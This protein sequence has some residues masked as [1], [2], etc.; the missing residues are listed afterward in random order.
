MEKEESDVYYQH[1]Q[2]TEMGI[3]ES[4]NQRFSPV[5]QEPI[6]SKKLNN[7]S[8]RKQR[9]QESTSIN[10]RFKSPPS[11]PSLRQSKLTEESFSPKKKPN[12]MYGCPRQEQPLHYD[13]PLYC[14]VPLRRSILSTDPSQSKN[15]T[16][17]QMNSIQALIEENFHQSVLNT[18]SSIMSQHRKPPPTLVFHL[19]HNILLAKQ[20]SSGAECFRILRQIQV[21]HPAVPAQMMSQKITWEFFSMVVNLSECTVGKCQSADS[22]L[23]LNASL[24]LSFLI[25]TMEEEAKMKKFS[26]VKTSAYRLLSVIKRLNNIRDVAQWIGCSVARHYAE[27]SDHGCGHNLCPVSL[28]QRMLMLS[29]L[30]SERPEDSAAR[31]AEELVI[32]YLQLQSIEQKAMFLQSMQSHL[33]RSKVIEVI[34]SNCPSPAEQDNKGLHG[35]GFRRILFIDFKRFPPDHLSLND[36]AVCSNTTNCEEFVMILAYWLQ[37]LVFCQ[38]KSH[39]KNP[40]EYL[41]ML[42]MDDVDVLLNIDQEVW[43]LRERLEDLCSPSPLTTRSYQLL[44]MMSALKSIGLKLP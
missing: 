35:V 39:Q 10:K 23:A 33:V 24:A 4:L 6:C 25:S 3:F 40:S 37:S 11:S 38:N 42:S 14:A 12:L 29:L 31:I 5:K 1:S 30:V 28:L 7:S 18:I 21:L 13:T 32:V 41:R 22:S 43:K 19:L 2:T 26:L 20:S 27:Q 36:D 9:Y 34:V 17:T 44:D 8:C 16:A 15:F